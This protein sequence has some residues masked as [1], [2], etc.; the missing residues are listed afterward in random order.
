MYHQWERHISLES[1]SP[2]NY[3]YSTYSGKRGIGGQRDSLESTFS[4]STLLSHL[5]EGGRG[6]QHIGVFKVSICIL[7]FVCVN[8]LITVVTL[9]I[10]VCQG[11]ATKYFTTFILFDLVILARRCVHEISGVL[12]SAS[13]GLRFIFQL[14][15]ESFVRSSISF[16]LFR[17]SWV[18]MGYSNWSTGTYEYTV[19]IC[20]PYCCSKN[21]TNH[22]AVSRAFLNSCLWHD[23]R[24]CLY[25]YVDKLTS[26]V[27][28]FAV[29]F[30]GVSQS[31]LPLTTSARLPILLVNKAGHWH[32]MI[33]TRSSILMAV[34]TCWR[35]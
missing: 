30:F 12:C 32:S 28:F 33:C 16:S 10:P 7:F 8:L 25:I 17:Y 11:S 26:C 9:K 3:Y 4:Y 15:T 6:V 35:E 13:W 2:H 29:T 22:E 1:E 20:C 24:S 23:I 18:Y 5:R 34:V 21:V 14:I 27:L 19:I 31:H